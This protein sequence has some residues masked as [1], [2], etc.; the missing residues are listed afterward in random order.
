M[1][2]LEG[3]IDEGSLWW[4][5]IRMI[6][7]GE[8][9]GGWTLWC[10]SAHTLMVFMSTH[11]VKRGDPLLLYMCCIL[12]N[13]LYLCEVNI[14]TL[15]CWHDCLCVVVMSLR[16]LF[17]CFGLSLHLDVALYSIAVRRWLSQILGFVWAVCVTLAAFVCVLLRGIRLCIFCLLHSFLL[18]CLLRYVAC[19]LRAVGVVGML[20]ENHCPISLN[21][22]MMLIVL[23]Q[24]IPGWHMSSQLWSRWNAPH[25]RQ[26]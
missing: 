20:R 1:G 14:A 5:I 2:C 12:G 25:S 10:G 22:A 26:F 21:N 23:Y 16:A 19:R 15:I 8:N 24:P 6:V 11:Y 17:A 7:G 18:W 3:G 13:D 9:I 4:W